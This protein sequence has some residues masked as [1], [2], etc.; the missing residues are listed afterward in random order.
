MSQWESYLQEHKPRFVDELLELLRIASISALS[1]H[2]ADVRRAADWVAGRLQRAGVE[3][4]EVMP[5]GGHPVVYGEWLHAPGRPTVL[6]Y[7]HFDVQ[8]ADPLHLW[9][10]P[11]FE[12]TIRDGRVYAR[13]AC[14][15]KGNLLPAII[16]VEALLRAE[17]ALPVNCKF[18]CEG[19]EEIG[20]PQLDRFVAAHK[21]KLACDL[22][23][24]TDGGQWSETEPS[25]LVGLRGICSLEIDVRGARSD[26]HS[27]GY[28]G[29]VQNPLHA[30]AQLVTS[31]HTPEG[32][33]AVEG[34]YDGVEVLDAAERARIAAVPFD[35]AEYKAQIGVEELFGEPGYS[36]VE[37][38]WVRPTLEV[39]GLWGGFQGEGTKTVLPS[40]A[41]AKIT[42]RLVP[43]QDPERVLDRIE[44]HLRRHR[45]QGVQVTVRRGSASARPYRVPAD[46]A[47]NRAARAVLAG[48]YGCEPYHVRAGGS[49]PICSILL[50]HLDAYAVGFGFGLRDEQ[51]HAPD[52]FFRLASFERSQRA[53]CLLLEELAGQS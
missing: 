30:L 14:D 10:S 24:N 53:F 47:G 32:A 29:A 5:T 52:E 12:P 35:E 49:V 16:A 51:V 48:L 3:A 33:V 31:L 25:L 6:V 37:R 11:P 40:E 17:G 50:E 15:N 18:L 9:T 22:V 39:N 45:P 13:G 7:G 1:E 21:G 2:A 8:P 34:F 28:G 26:L 36:T 41:H 43:N 19:Q 20:S 46:H 4:V 44:A 38:T 23:I 27:G 42:C